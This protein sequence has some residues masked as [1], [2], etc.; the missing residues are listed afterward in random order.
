V[1]G[2]FTGAQKDRVFW[3][4]EFE[5]Y[6]FFYSVW[7]RLSYD[8]KT[9]DKA[10]LAELQRRFGA[11]A[12]DVLE[13]YKQSGKVLSQI[14]AAHLADP[15]MYIWPEINPGGL[16]DAYIDVRPSDWRMIAAIPEAVRNRLDG[17]A[18]AKQ[19]PVETTQLL[20]A[21]A[22][23]TE[24]AVAR[25][26]AKM[27]LTNIEWRSSQ[28]DFQVLAALARYH[29]QKQLAAY[30][31]ALF[32]ATS[33]AS[34]L[35]EARRAVEAGIAIWEKLVQLTDDVYP[36]QMAF[37]PDDVGQWKD[38]LPYVR[39]DLVLIEEREKILKQFGRFEFGFDFGAPVHKPPGPA[40]RTDSYVWRNTL[41]PRFLPVDPETKFDEKLGYGWL[42]D[43]ERQAEALPLTPYPEVRATAKNPQ[44]LPVNMLFGDSIR[45]SGPQ[46]FRV[47][48]GDGSF[49]ISLL[50]PNGQAG[51]VRMEAREG[52]LDIRMPDGDWNISGI[53]IRKD[54][55]SQETAIPP[56]PNTLPRPAITHTAPTAAEPNQPLTL[57]LKI[58]PATNL[59]TV[60]LHYRPVNQL[61][62]FKTLESQSPNATFTI[63]AEDV[64]AR[65]DLLYYFEVLN[66]QGGGWFVP[67]PL[68][69]TPYFVVKTEKPEPVANEHDAKP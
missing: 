35:A 1:W 8:P 61:A 69:A 38:K 17:V 32:D 33:N 5:R 53:V 65:W 22:A 15:N 9:P 66:K 64:S 43:G 56:L 7:G 59:R 12:A 41:E 19:T 60:R 27:P 39:H 25:A 48:T 52:L 37:G 42:A 63:P 68:V 55:P 3:Q 2:V 16:L 58:S 4:W 21:A 57:A 13:T 26:A 54:P 20:S 28:P 51:E 18:S 11:A 10:F 29:A 45:G 50:N 24:Q 40:Y 31:V 49:A 36:A 30:N 34:A 44:H 62:Q 47:K 14:L 23:A 46:I 6:W 67:D